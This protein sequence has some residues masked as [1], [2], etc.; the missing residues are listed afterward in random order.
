MTYQGITHVGFSDESNWNKGRFRSLGLAT[1][2]ECYLKDLENEISKLLGES[3]IE[4]FKWKKLKGARERFAAEKLC[5][6][7]I[8]NALEHKLRIDVLIWDIQDSRH[9]IPRRDDIA[10][11]QRMYYHLFRNVLRL[12][13]PNDS[14]W[15]LY[16]DIN[17]QINWQMIED[18]LETNSVG[19]EIEP[20]L[21]SRGEFHLRLKREFGVKCI[22]PIDSKTHPLLHLAD[23]FAGIAVFSYDKYHE[24]Q[25]WLKSC[26]HQ[27]SLLD[28][29][30]KKE[31]LSNR[32]RERFQVIKKFDEE[33]KK[34]RLGVSLKKQNGFYTYNP[35]NPINFWFYKSQNAE[36]KAPIRS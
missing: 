16:P 10:N 24:Y 6:F 7:A 8:R 14:I 4:E 26:S 32:E 29:G 21:L 27:R 22:Q 34:H 2:L 11:L 3:G 33:C 9:N 1:T 18:Y 5:D 28:E 36:D 23:L 19:V 20:P 15:Q 17:T 25:I 12:R 13:W 30:S 31:E 35:K